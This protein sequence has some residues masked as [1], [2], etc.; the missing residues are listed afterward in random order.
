MEETL[1]L[2]KRL[3]ACRSITPDQ[4]GAL[5]LAQERLADAGFVCTRMPKNG[6]DN[7]WAIFGEA[8]RDA[9]GD[10][11]VDFAFAG[12]ID[13]VP[14]GDAAWT[15]DPF[16]AVER[17]G[18]LFGRGAADMKTSVAAMIV[19]C[20][21][22]AATMKN[23]A[24]SL[25]VILTSDEEGDAKDG[26][27][28]IVA[29]LRARKIRLRDCLLGEPTSRRVFGDA[30]KIGRRG[31][32]TARVKIIGKQGHAGHPHRADNPIHRLTAA[33]CALEK[34]YRPNLEALA[35]DDS[36]PATTFQAVAIRAGAGAENVIP[37]TAAA[38][39]NFRHAAPDDDSI[40]R[41]K[42]ERALAAVGAQ[43]E[44]DWR[45]GARPFRRD[46]DSPLARALAATVAAVAEQTPAFTSG[47]GTS[48]GRY[49]TEISDNLAEFGPLAETI[50]QPDECVALAD[51]GR[52]T[53]IYR[54]AAETR[55]QTTASAPTSL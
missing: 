30:I 11:V 54:R 28:H 24:A 47:G 36:H 31:S 32:L 44:I 1:D 9:V 3:I 40:L 37:Q 6:V 27:A 51:I 50:H 48:D 42:V 5:D 17:D 21:R 13:V 10:G 18:F 25:A 14:P 45:L 38:V 19:A 39:L 46:A 55:L 22:L 41:A 16:A 33:I 20:R 23:N 29:T 43:S 7:L 12:H 4:A 8:R 2:A 26:V 15:S 35:A 53:E 52:L 49:L 34:E